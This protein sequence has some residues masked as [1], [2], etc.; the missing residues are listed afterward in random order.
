MLGIKAPGIDTYEIFIDKFMWRFLKKVGQWQ[1]FVDC[2]VAGFLEIRQNYDRIARILQM[3]LHELREPKFVDKF[4]RNKLFLKKG[5]NQE[6]AVSLFTKKLLHAPLCSNNNFKRRF[7]PKFQKFV[8]KY[9]RISTF[10]VKKK[11]KKKPRK[12]VCR[13]WVHRRTVSK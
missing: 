8:E 7:Y 1:S 5:I 10:F 13:K 6:K 4:L 9:P 12:N 2:T 11:I 3:I